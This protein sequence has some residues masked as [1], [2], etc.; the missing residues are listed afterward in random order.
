MDRY[1]HLRTEARDAFELRYEHQVRP[2]TD[3]WEFCARVLARH[4]IVAR[5][6]APW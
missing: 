3:R 5:L 1:M 6:S 2:D 4:D